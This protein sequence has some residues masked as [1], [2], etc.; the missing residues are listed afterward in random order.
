MLRTGDRGRIDENGFLVFLGRIKDMLK[1]GGENVAAAEIEAFIQGLPGVQLVQV[2]GMADDRMGEVPVAFVALADE[3]P[4]VTAAEL[5]AWCR[6]GLATYK[7]PR[8]IRFVA[9]R[10]DFPRSTSGKVQR[11]TLEAQLQAETAPPV[12]RDVVGESAA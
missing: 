10:D 5:T 9:S 4:P 2:I 7:C 3:P 8:E 12:A 1:V 11:K 6:A